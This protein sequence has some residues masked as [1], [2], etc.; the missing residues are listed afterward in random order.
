MPHP[1]SVNSNCSNAGRG[2]V[3]YL[4]PSSFPGSACQSVA[5]A[6]SEVALD[7]S[8]H[9][10]PPRHPDDHRISGERPTHRLGE[11]PELL[12]LLWAER[13]FLAGR[14]CDHKLRHLWEAGRALGKVSAAHSRVI[15]AQMPPDPFR[16]LVRAESG[17]DVDLDREQSLS[18]DTTNP[19]RHRSFRATVGT[20]ASQ[21][22]RDRS[23]HIRSLL[24]A[25]SASQYSSTSTKSALQ[26][27]R[28][29][30]KPCALFRLF[31]RLGAV[32][33]V[34]KEADRFRL[35]T[36]V[37]QRVG[38]RI[39]GGRPF[40]RGHIYRML[41]NPIHIRRIAHRDPCCEGQHPAI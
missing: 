19:Y 29:M 32:R 26:A 24:G 31:L 28:P 33:R 23:N 8:R 25:S 18:S 5:P 36:K 12:R 35:K 34:K 16:L 1:W 27:W 39:G 41:G 38:Q 22:L 15:P 4:T 2:F 37:R 3:A 9:F 17:N 11:A 21:A 40:S 7:W 20:L 10:L 13:W 14:Y 6:I 30:R